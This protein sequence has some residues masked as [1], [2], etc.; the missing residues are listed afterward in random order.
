MPFRE[1]FHLLMCIGL[2][3]GFE[4]LRFRFAVRILHEVAKLLFNAH[5][6]SDVT[7]PQFEDIPA[8]VL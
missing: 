2:G 8:C 7:L 6:L 1:K 5:Q 4:Y 3:T